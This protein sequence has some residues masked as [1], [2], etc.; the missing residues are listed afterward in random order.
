MIGN[1]PHL[2]VF[3]CTVRGGAFSNTQCLIV[4]TAGAHYVF[5]CDVRH[6]SAR[7]VS[8]RTIYVHIDAISLFCLIIIISASLSSF[9]LVTSVVQ[10]EHSVG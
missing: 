8:P 6:Q 1:T 4:V 7:T 9:L 3:L 2:S 5:C 10:V